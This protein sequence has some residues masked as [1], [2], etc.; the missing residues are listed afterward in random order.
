VDAISLGRWERVP[1][2]FTFIGA[3]GADFDE[4]ALFDHRLG[5]FSLGEGATEL[6][7]K[8]RGRADRLSAVVVER[9]TFARRAA[10]IEVDTSSPASEGLA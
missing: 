3:R 4:H 6:A 2:G 5:L 9:G 8:Q 10:S 7:G 1:Y